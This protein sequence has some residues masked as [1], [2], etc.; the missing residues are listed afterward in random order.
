MLFQIPYSRR[1]QADHYNTIHKLVMQKAVTTGKL[2]GNML[3]YK[4]DHQHYNPSKLNNRQSCRSTLLRQAIQYYY[5]LE[6]MT[7]SDEPTTLEISAK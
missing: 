6:T 7:S 1:I 2:H 3:M 4:S 5:L